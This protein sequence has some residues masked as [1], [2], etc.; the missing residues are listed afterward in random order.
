MIR[1]VLLLFFTLSFLEASNSCIKCHEGIEDILDPHSKMRE[2]IYKVASKAGHKGN[3]CIVCHGGNP[4]SMV[5]ER[6]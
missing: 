4:Q 1:F 5:K 3:D 2:A 6:A